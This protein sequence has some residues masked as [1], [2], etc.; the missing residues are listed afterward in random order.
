MSGDFYRV[1]DDLTVYCQDDCHADPWRET[2]ETVVLLHGALE[3]SDVWY[4]W[5]PHLTRRY[6]VLRPDL[7]GHGR[8]TIPAPGFPW[9]P[10]K[11]SDDLIG[12]LDVLGVEQAHLVGGKVGGSTALLTAA[13]APDR[14]LSATA[15]SPL[16]YWGVSEVRPVDLDYGD[17]SFERWLRRS[18]PAR[19]GSEAPEAQVE[20]FTAWTL[21][22]TDPRLRVEI[23][24][25]MGGADLR[26]LFPQITSPTLLVSSET[27]GL[28]PLQETREW[29]EQL[30]NGEL[31]VLP[32][33]GYHVA[34]TQPDA[35][36]QGV[37]D[38]ITR[39]SRR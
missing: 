27:S 21:Q 16:V 28:T 24:K 15:I 14:V 19:L 4:A 20:W 25:G 37:A 22:H 13:R 30:P 5:L 39:H 7:R 34:V 12:L 2:P 9:S 38:F 29:S 32:G 10:A 3:T 36:A 35:C 31:L 11:L 1:A 26:E 8:S 18:M 33:D 17:D 23:L 6:R